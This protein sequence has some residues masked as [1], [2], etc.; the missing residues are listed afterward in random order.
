M[1]ECLQGLEHGFTRG[2]EIPKT[3]NSHML[4]VFSL[5]GGGRVLETSLPLH[6]GKAT[7]GCC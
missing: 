3:A 6:C 1:K 2:A 4:L 7:A 5:F